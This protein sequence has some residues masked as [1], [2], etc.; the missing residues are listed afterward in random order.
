MGNDVVVVDEVVV[1]TGNVV[2][3]V[4]L[5][6]VVVMLVVVVVDWSFKSTVVNDI[7][8]LL[9]VLQKTNTRKK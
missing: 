5:V 4:M 7:S 8:W 1:V 2:V 9:F 6:V 3:V